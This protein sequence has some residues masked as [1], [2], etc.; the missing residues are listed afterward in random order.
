M[1]PAAFSS[2][3]NCSTERISKAQKVQ[4]QIKLYNSMSRNMNSDFHAIAL[5]IIDSLYRN[6]G[7]ISRRWSSSEC[8]KISID[9]KR[10]ARKNPGNTIGVVKK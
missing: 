7:R 5:S 1:R 3:L 10:N 8:S 9:C 4:K 6:E 2:A